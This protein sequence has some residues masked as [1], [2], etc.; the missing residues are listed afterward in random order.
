MEL[1]QTQVVLLLSGVIKL[2][3]VAPAVGAAD[4]SGGEALCLGAA[5]GAAP[6][7]HGPAQVHQLQREGEG[8]R[9]R[10][11]SRNKVLALY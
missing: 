7:Q 8:P 2:Y 3:C 9:V 10:L 1:F 6:G 5:R 11:F 4:E